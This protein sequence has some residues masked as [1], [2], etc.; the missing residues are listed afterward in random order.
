MS[1][2]YQRKRLFDAL[3]GKDT[4]KITYYGILGEKIAAAH[5][6]NRLFNNM[7][8]QMADLAII[9]IIKEVLRFFAS[10]STSI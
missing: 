5:H 7:I 6:L 8:A 2:F 9:A 10:R 1:N 4:T 3:S